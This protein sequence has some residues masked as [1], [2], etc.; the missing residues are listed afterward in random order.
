MIKRLS[1]FIAVLFFTLFCNQNTYAQ[2]VIVGT[3]EMPLELN[4]LVEDY[5]T[6][7]PE[8]YEKILPIIMNID[9][10]ARSMNKEDI[11]IIGKI[12]VYKTFLRNYDA[13]I[14]LPIDGTTLATLRM[15]ISKTN[16]NFTKWFLRA[17]LKD[18]QDL[19][20]SPVYK[21]FL[22]LKSNNNKIEKMEYRKLE[23]KAELLQYWI[24]KVS[25]EAQ[26][27]PESL[28]NELAPK[29]LETLKNIQ[30]SFYFMAKEASLLP[31]APAL[32]N[33]SEL[34]FFTVKDTAPAKVAKPVESKSVED[35]LEPITGQGPSILP[36][37]TQENWIEDENTPSSLQNLPKP[38]NDADWLQDF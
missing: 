35:I 16:D 10:Y 9:L 24:S 1:T 27:F 28:R 13:P 31:I 12:E 6:L 4:L 20:E 21:E 37:P 23:K 17:L 36:R 18:S 7:A 5:Q 30:S 22:L 19:V 32:K 29:M 25:P 26:D 2:K 38:S 3:K 15:A 11:F 34:K 14:K 33:E 8:N